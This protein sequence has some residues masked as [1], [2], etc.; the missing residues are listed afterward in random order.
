MDAA[1]KAERTVHGIL[2][3][4]KREAQRYVSL[5][6]AQGVGEIVDLELQVPYP[7]IVNG[8]RIGKYT[9]DFRYRVVKTGEV[10]VEDVKGAKPRD[11]SRTKKLVRALHG[12]DIREVR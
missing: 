8:V 4:S 2:F 12:I 3:A 6:V 1:G 7:L 9:C 5:C 10:V 11:W